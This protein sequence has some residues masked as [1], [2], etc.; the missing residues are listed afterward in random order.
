[1]CLR[2]KKKDLSFL[3]SLSISNVKTIDNKIVHSIKDVTYIKKFLIS[4][5]I[6]LPYFQPNHA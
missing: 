6:S 5:G 2:H 4:Q 1:M 3:P